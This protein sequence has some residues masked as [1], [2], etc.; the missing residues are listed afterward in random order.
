[1]ILEG[2]NHG[3]E[4]E[5]PIT[6][7]EMIRD[8]DPGL[9][10]GRLIFIPAINLPAVNAAR[11]TSPIDDLNMNRTFPGNAN[12]TTTQQI[13]AFVN[14]ALFPMGDAFLDLHSGGSSLDL[15]PSSVIEPVADP[16]QHAKNVA[17]V[18][19]FD[20]PLVVV[21]DNRGDT[22]TAT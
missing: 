8:L 10:S 11:R 16:V 4:Y 18:T 15:M 12:G 9:V 20:A 17:A 5:G 13:S 19:A 21:I 2:G 14:D 22:R 1:V 3:D 7:G 6:L